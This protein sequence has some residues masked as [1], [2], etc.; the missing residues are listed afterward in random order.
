MNKNFLL[1]FKEHLQS[2][3]ELSWWTE[4]CF[5]EIVIIIKIFVLLLKVV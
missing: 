1:F 2:N 5:L 3:L 4:K